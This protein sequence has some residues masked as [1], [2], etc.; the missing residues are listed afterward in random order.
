MKLLEIKDVYKVYACN[1][2][3]GGGNSLHAYTL[4]TSLISNNF[5]IILIWP[6]SYITIWP[7]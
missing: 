6:K 3:G 1:E 5:I 4:W 7:I 2:L